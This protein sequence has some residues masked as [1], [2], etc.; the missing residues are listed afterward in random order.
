MTKAPAVKKPK[1]DLTLGQQRFMDAILSGKNVF[2]TGKAGTGKSF[3]TKHA[4]AALKDLGKR[5][6][7]I[8]PTGIAAN[9]IEGQ[10]I[11]SLFQLNPHGVMTL[12]DCTSVKSSKREALKKIDVIFIDEV[13]MLR[14]DVLDGMHWTLRKNDIGGLD[15]KQ[16]V[17]IGD[18]KQ[19][20]PVLDDNT[21]SVLFRTYDGEE[22]LHA[23]I[24]EKLS[25]QSVDLLEVMRQTNEEFIGHLNIIRD[26]GKSEYFRR[27]VADK[28]KGIILAPHNATVAQYNERGL[29]A[30]AGEQFTFK[31]EID[32][33]LKP[34]DYN[35]ENEIR[36]KNDCKIMYLANSQ[37]NPLRNGTLGIFI[38]RKETYY[39]KVG[40]VEYALEKIKATKKQY[41]YD[42]EKDDLVLKEVGSITQY[43]FKLAYAL[44]IHKAQGLTFDEV[45]LDL[46]RPC[47]QK[48]QMYVALSRV[49]TPEGL[50]IIR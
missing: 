39:I 16:I 27:F 40:G 24:M 28:P 18:L 45:T 41:V 9:N 49:R 12:E 26:G 33:E 34:E 44:S 43:P 32:A 22:F 23:K 20:P 37:N 36:V 4:I 35:L 15:T 30:Q 46:T 13:S 50:S 47:F 8:A 29:A 6:A 21:R 25:V 11:H 19:L 42:K 14:P 7:A 3:V 17:F 1:V 31:A 48:G 5:V 10:T 38:S 2:L